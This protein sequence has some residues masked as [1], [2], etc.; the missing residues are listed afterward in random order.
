MAITLDGNNEKKY[1]VGI[2][3]WYWSGKIISINP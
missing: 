1:L 2:R 3:I